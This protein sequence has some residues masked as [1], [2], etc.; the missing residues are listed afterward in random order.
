MFKR[1]SV[2]IIVSFF[3]LTLAGCAPVATPAV[4]LLYTNVSWDGGVKGATGPK[5][6]EACASALLGLFAFGDA[7]TETAAKNGAITNISGSD[8]TSTIILLG[9]YG[10]YCTI[11]YGS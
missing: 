3:A 8:H 9:I 2:A 1:V 10:E 6:G 7:S 4:G 5:R 11:A